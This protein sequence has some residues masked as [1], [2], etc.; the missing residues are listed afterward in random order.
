MTTS[1]TQ[2]LAL[3]ERRT[4]YAYGLDVTFPTAPYAAYE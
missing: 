4:P 3:Q 1:P 2:A